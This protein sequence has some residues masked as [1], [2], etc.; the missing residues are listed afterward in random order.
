MYQHLLR[1]T[2]TNNGGRGFDTG[3]HGWP[4]ID[5][6]SSG[7]TNTQDTFRFTSGCTLDAAPSGVWVGYDNIVNGA[8]SGTASPK[9]PPTPPIVAESTHD[10]ESAT[11]IIVVASTDTDSDLKETYVLYREWGDPSAALTE[12]KFS[13]TAATTT[14]VVTG[15]S[16]STPYIF[17]G[18]SR[19]ARLNVSALG[20]VTRIT[21]DA[22]P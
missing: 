18:Y 3:S 10:H 7:N 2:A 16:A 11:L 20:S 5:C 4:A 1:C 6:E 14:L 13:A 15:L 17:F 9:T 22:A 12:A 8:A 19:D 21:T